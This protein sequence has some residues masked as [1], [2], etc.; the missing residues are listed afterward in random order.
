MSVIRLDRDPPLL[1]R[2][3]TAL[4]RS[5]AGRWVYRRR[6]NARADVVVVSYPKAGR[7]WLRALL[8]AAFRDHHG[9][10]ADAHQL[11][12]LAAGRPLPRP[13][14]R[15]KF[16][17]DDGPQLK[18]PQELVADKSEYR[19]TRVIFLARDLRDLAVSAY[20]QM[21]RRERRFAGDLDA[22]LRGPR[23]G[24]DTMIRFFNIWAENREIPA[25]LM[26]IRY[27][28]LH[29]NPR[30]ELLRVLSFCG[31]PEVSDAT[32]DRAVDAASFDR[33][34]D[35]EA[36]GG[37]A[38]GR[39]QP[40][41]RNDPESFKTRRGQVGGFREYLSADQA[42]WVEGRMRRELSPW[43]GYPI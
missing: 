40:A 15:V 24:L 22:F 17:H 39:L 27:E 33:M 25:D 38:S 10:P 29:R 34:R 43:F 13:V 12:D 36:G 9:L 42:S 4:R 21:T 1:F 2:L 7:T 16:K 32:L 28:D 3:K 19:D 23:G 6:W 35:L 31:L 37:V 18:R 5:G 20:F 8:G 41:D 11:L 14:P 26:L 30:G